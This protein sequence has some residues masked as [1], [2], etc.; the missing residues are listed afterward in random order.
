MNKT[1]MNN[2][3]SGIINWTKVYWGSWPPQGLELFIK[4][5]DMELHLGIPVS[6]DEINPEAQGHTLAEAYTANIR[7]DSSTAK[8]HVWP[9]LSLCRNFACALFLMVASIWL[10]SSRNIVTFPWE[11][12]R[13][14]RIRSPSRRWA[15][16]S[17]GKL[18]TSIFWFINYLLH[19]RIIWNA[20]WLRKSVIQNGRWDRRR[21]ELKIVFLLGKQ[22][23]SVNVI[24]NFL[25]LLTFFAAHDGV[26]F[27][28]VDEVH[29]RLNRLD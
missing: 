24:F 7:F 17:G 3:Y 14:N 23:Q 6:T 2:E 21:I 5:K 8:R 28:P 16:L 10:S 15:Y 22:A 27:C 9:I 13:H 18:S 26:R 12:T 29:S 11:S 4:Y 25:I 19:G 20:K 1:C